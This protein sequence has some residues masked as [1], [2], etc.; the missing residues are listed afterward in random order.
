MAALDLLLFFSINNLSLPL[1]CLTLCV[2]HV[3]SENVTVSESVS[4]TEGKL[5]LVLH[6]VSKSVCKLIPES[7]AF[8]QSLALLRHIPFLECLSSLLI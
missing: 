5:R 2:A 1:F 4:S 6:S 3:A 8:K 7:F